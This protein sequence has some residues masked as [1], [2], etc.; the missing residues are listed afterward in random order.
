MIPFNPMF[1]NAVPYGN[2]PQAMNNPMANFM[3]FQ[4]QFNNFAQNFQQQNQGVSP[5]QMVQNMLNNG[6]MSQQQFNTFRMM[7]NQM[8]G[9]NF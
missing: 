5:Q 3:N 6:Q 2:Q 4:Q 9:M 8:T 1:N 7:A